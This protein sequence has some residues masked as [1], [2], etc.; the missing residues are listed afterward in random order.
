MKDFPID[1]K[2]EIGRKKVKV[3]SSVINN[4]IE[5][6]LRE[7]VREEMNITEDSMSPSFRRMWNALDNVIPMVFPDTL[8]LADSNNPIRPFKQMLQVG[9]V[10][11]I[12]EWPKVEKYINKKFKE[13]KLN[14]IK[15]DQKL[16]K[17]LS[18]TAKGMKV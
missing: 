14:K 1:D 11:A 12:K 15:E 18:K 10:N 6:R 2:R 5:N 17:V 16:L 3:P 8:S 13:I 4:V 9:D 7:M